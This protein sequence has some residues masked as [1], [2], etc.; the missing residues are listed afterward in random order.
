[1]INENK[2]YKNAIINSFDIKSDSIEVLN[3]AIK[4]AFSTHNKAT[5]FIKYKNELILYWGKKENAEYFQNPI[6]ENICFDFVYN[7][8]CSIEP[9]DRYIDQMG[10]DENDYGFGFKIRSPENGDRE[11][12]K[13]ICMNL[14]YGETKNIKKFKS[15]NKYTANNHTV[16]SVK[17][18]MIRKPGQFDD[19][20]PKVEIDGEIYD[21][22]NV[23]SFHKTICKK[24]DIIGIQVDYPLNKRI[25]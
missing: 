8:L 20:Y 2:L 10:G 5:C 24:G 13:I 14:Y 18:D 17:N 19:L 7:W 11:L 21:V 3:N 12:F 9:S 16:F 15:I 6:N 23:E 22:K 4:I 1:M 25:L